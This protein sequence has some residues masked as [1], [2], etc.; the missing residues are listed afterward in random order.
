MITKYPIVKH[1]IR[2]IPKQFSWVDHRLVR[3]RYIEKVSH[4]AAAL[5]LFLVAVGDANGLSYYGDKSIMK[6]LSMDQG[7]LQNA[8]SNLI[9]N[10][11]I[12]WQEPIYQV[13]SLELIDGS[14]K[15]STGQF[16]DL[17]SVLKKAMEETS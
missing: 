8:R 5:Y 17:G 10:K 16:L 14:K 4:Q 6:R 3:D 2:K 13:L 11:M 9:Q 7:M 12:A 15:T 1:R